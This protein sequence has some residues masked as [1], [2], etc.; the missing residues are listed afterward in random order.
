MNVGDKIK[1]SWAD[2]EEAIGFFVRKERGFAVFVDD[3]GEQFVAL[4]RESTKM[5][6]LEKKINKS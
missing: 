5:E 6:I 2:G 3:D 1:V 4:C